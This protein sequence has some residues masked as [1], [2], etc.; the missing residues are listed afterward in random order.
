MLLCYAA[1]PPT[2]AVALLLPERLSRSHCLKQCSRAEGQMNNI[3]RGS[4][5]TSTLEVLQNDCHHAVR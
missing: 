5:A 3:A 1:S 2:Q 4:T